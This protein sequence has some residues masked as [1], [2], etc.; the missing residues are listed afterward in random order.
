MSI[1]LSLTASAAS[2]D[3]AAGVEGVG[4]ATTES[5]GLT[6]RQ[7]E[8]GGQL[9]V[10]SV[11]ARVD[12][13]LLAPTTGFAD[14]LNATPSVFPEQAWLAVALSGGWTLSGGTRPLHVPGEAVDGWNNA[15]VTHSLGYARA[16]GQNQVIGGW[17]EGPAG[18]LTVGLHGGVFAHHQVGV[19]DLPLVGGSVAVGEDELGMKAACSVYP[20][21]DYLQGTVEGQLPVAEAAQLSGAVWLTGPPS[22]LAADLWAQ[23]EITPDKALVPVARAEWAAGINGGAAIDAGVAWRPQPFLQLAATGRFDG[24]PGVYVGLALFEDPEA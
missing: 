10:G 16:G 1:L 20:G 9:G 5:A 12:L 15:L 22:S 11:T 17:A 14:G 7:G 8:V 24:V 4:H 18:A 21:A 13:D 2:F 19:S 6:A 23:V 3:V